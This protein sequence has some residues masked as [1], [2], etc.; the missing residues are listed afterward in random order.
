MNGQLN[1]R[2]FLV[3]AAALATAGVAEAHATFGTEFEPAKT[4]DRGRALVDVNVTLSRWPFRHLPLDKTPALVARLR[5]YGVRQAWASSFD[6][7]LHKDISA[8]NERLASECRRHGR[9]LLRPFGVINPTLPDWEEDIR[10]CA[11][12]HR[13]PGVRLFPNYHGY[14]LADA[15]FARLLDLAQEHRLVVQVAMLLEDER[16]QH[17]LVR[18]P[19]VD[20]APLQPLV[21]A[22][23]GVRLVLLNWFRAVPTAL[24][25]QLTEAGV[26]FDT[27]TLEGVGGLENLLKEV[28][29]ERVLFGSHAPFFYFESALLKLQ[30]SAL[31][32]ATRQKVAN[33]EWRM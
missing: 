17:P 21:K 9:G 31:G 20:A 2:E 16:T 19:H 3:G 23:P 12:T 26:C 15:R 25:R 5:G 4:P 24:V 33:A 18:V 29:A 11:E 30:E 10:R 8:V 7:V 1:R 22:R 28:P 13:M 27:A 14:G 6:G 32:G